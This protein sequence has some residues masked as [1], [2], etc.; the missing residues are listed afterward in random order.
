MSLTLKITV[1][2][3]EE[4]APGSSSQATHEAPRHDAE[5][6]LQRGSVHH[7][8]A[9]GSETVL[10]FSRCRVLDIDHPGGTYVESSLYA[11]VGFRHF[12]LNNRQCIGSVLEAGGADAWAFSPVM[13]EHQLSVLRAMPPTTIA[14]MPG[15]PDAACDISVERR[16]GDLVYSAAGRVLASVATEGFDAGPELSSRFTLFLG[17]TYGGHPHILGRI[18][19][20]GRIP[21]ELRLA[22]LQ[23]MGGPGDAV[24]L[25]VASATLT[26]D[27]PPS[28]DAHRRVLALADADDVDAALE[29]ALFGDPVDLASVRAERLREVQEALDAGRPFEALLVI[30]ELAFET[31]TP[32]QELGEVMRRVTDPRARELLSIVG[33]AGATPEGCKTALET[34]ELARAVAGRRAHV[35]DIFAASGHT[36]LGQAALA[37]ERMTAALRV[38]PLLAC[39]YK[40][41]G[42]LYLGGYRT[43]K[44]WTCWE[45]ARRIAPGHAGL[46]PVRTMEETLRKAHPDYFP[47]EA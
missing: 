42:E 30:L 21:R 1:E 32:T 10:D 46:A 39:V 4:P 9:D 19:A 25:R 41:L 18:A 20:G 22:A 5:L 12:E 36:V 23:P 29:R 6:R 8:L 40:D 17:L 28:V 26:P 2:R 31:D 44:A 7:L 45:A 16:G 3:S 35:L 14:A 37:R 38:N 47:P 33:S 11:D 43:R 15:S 24:T 34:I 27:Q 13:S